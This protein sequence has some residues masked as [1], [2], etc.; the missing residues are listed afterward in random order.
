MIT[1]Q[2]RSQEAT[3]VLLRLDLR[4]IV[5]LPRCPILDDILRRDFGWIELRASCHELL[6]QAQLVTKLADSRWF[7]MLRLFCTD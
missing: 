4:E 1:T 3:R 6:E 5:P 7:E 2:T